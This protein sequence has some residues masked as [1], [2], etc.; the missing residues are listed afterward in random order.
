MTI[1]PGENNMIPI[2]ING[3]QGRMGQRITQLAMQDKDFKITA[4]LE[5]PDH[6]LI[7]KI[8]EGI[9]ISSEPTA[10]KKSKVLIDFTSPDSTMACLKTCAEAGVNCVIGTTGLTE[11]NLQAIKTASARIA[12]VCSSNMSIGVNILF[13]LAGILSAAAPDFY[14]V[15][16]EEAHHVH[17]KDAPS[18]TA[19]TL[20]RIIEES[21]AHRVEDIQS[22]REGEIVGDHKIIFESPEDC[23]VIDHHAK[24]RDIFAK[25][26]LEAAKF[27]S[28]QT[29]G[30][31]DMQDVLNI[32]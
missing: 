11:P 25:G 17:K 18:G 13:K 20:G 24:T 30:L 15:R 4:L 22:V 12:V 16:I 23:I 14:Q 26:A 8:Y 21:S 7:N 28:T 2:A 6:P 29:R 19:K 31:F 9:L 10:V 27:L 1:K 5:H 32:R 3:C